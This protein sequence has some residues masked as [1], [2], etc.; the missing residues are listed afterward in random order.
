MHRRRG[1][2][3]WA[4]ILAALILALMPWGMGMLGSASLQAHEGQAPDNKA[5]EAVYLDPELQEKAKA[6]L[7]RVLIRLDVPFMPE[8]Q[9]ADS[10]AVQ[11]QRQQ[12]AQ[13]GQQL[14]AAALVGT[15]TPVATFATIPFVALMV[16]ADGLQAL[17]AN[18]NV[19]AIAEDY[20]MVPD[21]LMRGI[22]TRS[23]TR[24]QMLESNPLIGAP[25]A[26]NAGYTGN[27]WAVAVID[28]GVGPHAFLQNRITA[29]ACFSS[30]G[31]FGQSSLCPGGS[32]AEIG[33]GTGADCQLGELSGC[34]HGTHVAGTVAG[35]NGP[36]GLSG[37]A[38]GAEIIAIKAAVQ[39]NNA[40]TCGGTGYTPCVTFYFSDL[41]LGLEHVL[42]LHNDPAFSTPIAAVNLSVGG[43]E[44]T[45]QT[46]CDADIGLF[47]AAVDNLR[48]VGIATVV[49]AGNMNYT[50]SL[51]TPACL[52]S[53]ISVGGV[54]DGQ[55]AP[56]YPAD[57]IWGYPPYYG[58]NSADFLDVLAP[59]SWIISADSLTGGYV[60]KEG[61]SM[62]APHVAGA[63]AL[64]RQRF[65]NAS[66]DDVL[67]VLQQSGKPIV[68][69]RS[70]ANNR[71]IP[72]IQV[73]A[74]LSV[75][76]SSTI[77]VTSTLATMVDDGLCTLPEA[78]RA[79]NRD[80]ASGSTA[81]ECA[82]GTGA[83]TIVLT[84][85]TYELDMPVPSFYGPTGLP[86]IVSDLTIVG[87]GATIRRNPTAA[88]FRL[89]VVEGTAALTLHNLT[90]EQGLAQGGKAGYGSA[91]GGGGAGL[92][93]AI[94]NR[95]MLTLED[96]SLVSNTARGGDGGGGAYFPYYGSG[97]GGGGGMGGNGANSS[98]F[99]RDSGY[100]YW[101]QRVFS[102][103]G[104]G[105]NQ[106]NGGPDYNTALGGTAG[107]DN[108][109]SG[110]GYHTNLTNEV[111]ITTGGHGG[112]GSGGGGGALLT[113]PYG[114]PFSYTMSDSQVIAYKT[115]GNGGFGGGGG[116][117]LGQGGFGGG[118]GGR[119]G[120][121][122]IA[123]AGAPGGFGAG[124]GG[125]A[126]GGGGGGMGGA[127]FND[128]GSVTLLNSSVLSNTAQGGT[129]G[130]TMASSVR[131]GGSGGSAFG[132]AIF[133]RDGTLALTAT[134]VS[135][136]NVLAG[137]GRAGGFAGLAEAPGI[138]L[139]DDPGLTSL[140]D[141]RAD[142][143][144]LSDDSSL[145]L[146]N[147]VVHKPQQRQYWGYLPLIVR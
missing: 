19:T 52:S 35:A 41:A 131:T 9:L 31:W 65:P 34:G 95:G 129:G 147:P 8:G 13:T 102:S 133:S 98:G 45:N 57:T 29:E 120:F 115:G 5:S 89:L 4:T 126:G 47:K 111:L 67:A 21:P 55:F 66:V 79:A 117:F 114:N 145:V 99:Y 18:P 83:D 97:N 22:A 56:A 46:V 88:P 17:A 63:W 121:L 68:D 81:G 77:T 32:S 138:Y 100:W 128:A 20:A 54:E 48:S 130:N 146:R 91:G 3:F 78:I 51:Q 69:T 62:A 127:M 11:A 38:P 119:Y 53:T 61:T 49:A 123:G 73:D 75:G 26:H 125:S 107:L 139:Y 44:Y 135:G 82:A 12:I 64:L 86:P 106:G 40:N 23:A 87:N 27:G 90:L 113:Q 10:A 6:G 93:G 7:V 50:S 72:R 16:D 134:V 108:G 30:A 103:G 105:G 14:V 2:Q 60:G 71:I 37:V 109:G 137:S 101:Q 24:L 110:A 132:G 136:N 141:I 143:D 39:E 96:V 80:W 140:P 43:A 104:G 116:G 84:T 74:A 36:D 76:A 112:T 58:S 118:G 59:A 124:A 42:S 94:F 15:A 142:E 1:G 144:T 28:S 122:G 92:G 25:G 85:T 33:T 70:G